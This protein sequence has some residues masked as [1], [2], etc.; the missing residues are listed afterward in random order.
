MKKILISSDV[1]PITEKAQ[2]FLGRSDVRVFTANT[3]REALDI[4][5]AENMDLIITNLDMPG[6]SGEEFCS[7]IREDEELCKVSIIIICS[8]CNPD[9][10]RCSRCRANVFIRRPVKPQALLGKARQ[11]LNIATRMFYRVPV[12]LK[13]QGEHEEGPFLGH[14]ENISRSGML[15]E[16]DK[17]LA[18]GDIILCSFFLSDTTRIVTDAEIVRVID[19]ISDHDVNLFGIRFTDLAADLASAIDDFVEEQA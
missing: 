8:N 13:V 2:S 16:A 3:N 9:I 5:R 7:A 19:T 14:S 11:L 1:I 12:G 17:E 10:E 6:L 18:K 15:I 4:H